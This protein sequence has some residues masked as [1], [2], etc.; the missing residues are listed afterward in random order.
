MNTGYK[1]SVMSI[2]LRLLVI[3]AACVTGG[4]LLFIVGYILVK[5]IPNL[6]PELFAWEY[7]SDNLSMLPSL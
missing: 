3:I 2:I 6:S 7:N 1:K 5:G 4:V